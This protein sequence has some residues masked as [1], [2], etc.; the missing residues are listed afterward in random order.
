MAQHRLQLLDL[1][2]QSADLGLQLPLRL[3]HLL[4]EPGKGRGHLP[5]SDTHREHTV[6]KLAYMAGWVR[7][8]W[9]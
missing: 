5:G 8:G 7:L 2:R 9:L 4:A 6:L 3:V 1:G